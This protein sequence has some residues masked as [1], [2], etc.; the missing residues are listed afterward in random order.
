MCTWG[1]IP[2][3]TNIFTYN[4]IKVRNPKQIIKLKDP[5]IYHIK[6]T[7]PVASYLSN[8]IYALKKNIYKD[9]FSRRL[10]FLLKN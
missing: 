7:R 6:K 2:R 9:S 5:S 3:R 4:I 10:L 1:R 8:N